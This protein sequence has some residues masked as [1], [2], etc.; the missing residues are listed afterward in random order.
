MKDR[1]NFEGHL[2]DGW[3][4][5]TALLDDRSAALTVVDFGTGTGCLLLALL[6][7]LPQAR[8]IG[9][10]IAPEA[11]ATA[12]RNAEALGLAARH[13]KIYRCWPVCTSKPLTS[14]GGMAFRPG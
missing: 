13:W 6:S 10:D 14:P 5:I 12:R 9:I 8:G 7:E 11:V 4:T 2:F 1:R 3:T